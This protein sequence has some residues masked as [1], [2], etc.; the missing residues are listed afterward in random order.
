[1]GDLDL[2]FKVE[3][4]KLKLL[5]YRRERYPFS[6]LW[7]QLGWFS[8]AIFSRNMKGNTNIFQVTNFRPLSKLNCALVYKN[9]YKLEDH[10]KYFIGNEKEIDIELYI[11]IVIQNKSQYTIHMPK[12][13][14]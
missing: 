7:S 6:Y 5:T 1:M 12:P 4:I 3:A 8:S 2:F 11:I 10:N 9:T 13:C 14:L